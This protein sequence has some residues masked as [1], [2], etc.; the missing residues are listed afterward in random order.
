MNLAVESRIPGDRPGTLLPGYSQRT[1]FLGCPR[2]FGIRSA[3]A[4][5]FR[6]MPLGVS[7]H[8][9]T[10]PASR[11]QSFGFVGGN[12]S[13]GL[14]LSACRSMPDSID[15]P[16]ADLVNSSSE[17]GPDST[18]TEPINGNWCCSASCFFLLMVLHRWLRVREWAFPS[19]FG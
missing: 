6:G 3:T 13:S 10:I 4:G 7:F 12:S 11:T 19:G 8:K 16:C 15:S 18:V 17:L 14:Q 2:F 1:A 5:N 9:T